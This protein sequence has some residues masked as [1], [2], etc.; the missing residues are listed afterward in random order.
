MSD[1][2]HLKLLGDKQLREITAV[3]FN[4]GFPKE[5]ENEESKPEPNYYYMAKGLK[6]SIE[7]FNSDVYV[8][9]Q[10]RDENITVPAFIDYIE[11]HFVDQFDIKKFYKEYYELFG[12]EGISFSNFGRSGLFAIS[13]KL[14]FNYYLQN[15]YNFIEFGLNNDREVK[16]SEHLKY[17]KSFK[18]LTSKDIIR[19]K[20]D[21]IGNVVYASTIELPLDYKIQLDLVQSLLTYL[22]EKKIQYQFLEDDNRIELVN[23]DYD[24]LKKLADNFDIIQ[25]ITC[26]LSSSIQPSTFNTVKRDYNFTISN[27]EEDLPLIGIIDTGISMQTPLEAITLKDNS[28]SLGGDPLSDT[29]GINRLGHGTSVA[30]LAALGRYNHLNKFT[31]DVRADAKLLSIKL[32]DSGSSYISETNLIKMLYDVKIKYPEIKC[33]VLTTCYMKFKAKNEAFSSYTYELDKFS[34][35]TDSIIFICTAN[36][37]NAIN[38]NRDYNL[39]Y[40]NGDHTNLCTPADSMNNITVGA[41]A[42]NLNN[43]I[44]HGI[45]HGREYPTLF[46]R[47]GHI[48]LNVILPKTKT[49]KN[50]FKP[51]ILDCGGDFGF[52]NTTT[53]DFTDPPALEIMSARPEIG[54]IKETGTS[55]SA[56]LSANLAAKIQKEYPSLNSQTI[57]ALIINGAS[58]NNIKFPK[59]VAHLLNSVAGHGFVDV[60]QSL[61]SKNIAPTIIL[62]DSIEN[63]A[64][65][66]YPINFPKYLIEDDLG[67]KSGILKIT[68]TLCFHFLPIQ[69]N[70]LSYN[71]IHMA[72]CFFKN[73]SGDQINAKNEE[74]NSKLRS[75]LNW[76]QSG[77]HVSKPIPYSNSQKV[78]FSID[79]D[80]LKSENLILNLAVQ[81]KLTS[82]VVGDALDNYPK[83]F[84]FSLVFTVEENFK[85]SRGKLYDEIQLI[86]HL[87]ILQDIELEDDLEA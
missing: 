19:F 40:F 31:G 73:H 51:D 64:M 13:D 60:E 59:T 8:R 61:F 16:F 41:A 10:N 48:D 87:E 6:E 22:D 66:I 9:G 7:R 39:D 86:N 71:P 82:Q 50:Y 45:S 58:L 30:A 68:A 17:A 80:H 69:N 4:Y 2:K 25:S 21:E 63:G 20:P 79:V 18:L 5:D 28:F 54:F 38:D 12:L 29:A 52:Y 43:D 37:N 3:K 49:N 75:T 47:K 70:Q 36:N 85:K 27:A 84:P 35:E 78:N 15:I 57:K 67:R 53:I 42:E 1:K 46:T 56:P 62:E 24:E 55:L 76:S 26:S 65:K 44:F 32:S 83:T 74:Y 77:R 14:K 23:V 72:F 34:H 81:S 33:F 11:L